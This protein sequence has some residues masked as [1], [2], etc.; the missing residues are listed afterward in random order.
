VRRFAARLRVLAKARR[1]NVLFVQKE[2]FPWLPGF[3]EALADAAH[4]PMVLDVDDAIYLFYRG[5]L[6]QHKIDRV[7]G[8]CELVLAGN[9]HL[10]E[11][12][13]QFARRTELFPT[14]VD[15]RKFSPAPAGER[16]GDPTVGWIGSPETVAYL[17]ALE[18]VL[19]EV[20]TRVPFR[21]C[22]VGADGSGFRRFPVD[23]HPWS[24]QTEVGDIRSM[25]VGIMP[26]P[27]SEW[28]DGKCGLK[29]LQYMSCGVP[30]VAT[31]RGSTPDILRERNAGV[32]ARTPEEWSEGL[33][34]LLR[35]ASRRREM[36]RHARATVRKR[37][38][39]EGAA[40]RLADI[41][42]EVAGRRGR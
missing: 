14:V 10:A 18:P 21:L 20:Y 39:L 37:F 33:T 8:H 29:L 4:I 24:E 38:S 11:Y 2:L 1:Y 9:R 23:T 7:M 12:A 16:A 3:F 31:P 36:G 28:A 42:I 40:P 15:T 30:A 27:E 41:L 22:V 13:A 32:C 25:D 17:Q 26:L 34:M 35:S 19:H 5:R 6:L